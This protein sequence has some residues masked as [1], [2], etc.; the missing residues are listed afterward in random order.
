MTL[1]VAIL[2]FQFPALTAHA[3]AFHRPINPTP[4]ISSPSAP[5]DSLPTNNSSPKLPA[6]LSSAHI[7]LAAQPLPATASRSASKVDDVPAP[8]IYKPK[9]LPPNSLTALTGPPLSESFLLPPPGFR[10]PLQVPVTHRSWWLAL[11][12]A[13]H[14]AAAYDAWSTRNA[15]SSGR[16]EADPLMRPF[17]GSAAIYPAIQLIPFGLDYLGHRLER[18]SG[19]TH[20]FWWLPQSAAT[21][22]FLFSGSYNVAH[23]N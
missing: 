12:T 11:S 21:V 15:I 16:V 17:A 8:M 19:W 3:S 10:P 5:A 14:S 6:A 22:T 7:R 1:A 9:I 4:A 23:T 2:L 20:H 18:S 13:E